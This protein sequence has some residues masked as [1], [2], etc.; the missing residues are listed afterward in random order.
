MFCVVNFD[1]EQS[2]DIQILYE[3]YGEMFMNTLL[4]RT[5]RN[6]EIFIFPKFYEFVSW[7][8]KL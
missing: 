5:L 2:K 1:C 6:W 8:K 7:K 3:D 4:K